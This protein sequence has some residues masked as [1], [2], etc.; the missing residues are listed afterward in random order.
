MVFQPL[1][2]MQ[3]HAIVILGCAVGLVLARRRLAVIGGCV[4][5]YLI[6]PM[7]FAGVYTHSYYA[8]G[9]LVFFLAAMGLSI[10]G[11]LE[12]GGWRKVV[13]VV[14]FAATLAA[15]VYQHQTLYLPLQRHPNRWP[16][17]IAEMIRRTTKPEDVIV[18]YGCEWSPEIPYYAQRRALMLPQWIRKR[19]KRPSVNSTTCR[20]A[21][22]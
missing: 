9:T 10:V 18:I 21:R 15:A 22:W 17:R 4:L 3:Y 13:G 19:P 2:D 8:I 14:L 1:C 20:S 12:R 11:L 6:A 7:I 16:L 5:L